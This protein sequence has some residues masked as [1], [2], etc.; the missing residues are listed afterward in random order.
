MRHQSLYKHNQH[1]GLKKRAKECGA[2]IGF[3]AGQVH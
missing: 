3:E 2:D 1:G